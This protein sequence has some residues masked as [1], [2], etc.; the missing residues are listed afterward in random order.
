MVTWL[1]VDRP[2]PSALRRG[3]SDEM[4]VEIR[5]A[6]T[7]PGQ[8][9]LRRRDFIEVDLLYQELRL[10]H[11]R[12]RHHGGANGIHDHALADVAAAVLVAG[13]IDGDDEDATLIGAASQREL[14]GIAA[15]HV[16]AVGRGADGH[17]DDFG[18]LDG[19]RARALREFA[20][21]ADL[22]SDAHPLQLEDRQGVTRCEIEF[23]VGP[24]AALRIGG[25]DGGDM[26][27]AVGADMTPCTVEHGCRGVIVLARLLSEGK[28]ERD[29][30]ATRGLDERR[31]NR[32]RQLQEEML[33]VR[34]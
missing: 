25:K 11:A 22:N 7:P 21:V 8:A 13:A 27:F 14:P 10:I 16:L 3:P 23:L 17:E 26:R 33:V 4:L 19:E 18:A 2:P 1:S 28:D 12:D 20:I 24:R 34:P 9:P 30:M 15:E 31:R 29:I 5:P 6:I 32:I